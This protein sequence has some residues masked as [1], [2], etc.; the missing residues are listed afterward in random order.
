MSL[1]RATC[2]EGIQKKLVS[3]SFNW[4]S[5]CN[6]EIQRDVTIANV[7]QLCQKKF[8]LQPQWM[9]HWHSCHCRR[10][11]FYTAVCHTLLHSYQQQASYRLLNKHLSKWQYYTII[12][13]T[14]LRQVFSLAPLILRDHCCVCGLCLVEIVPDPC[15]KNTWSSVWNNM[16]WTEVGQ[17]GKK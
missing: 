11:V 12:T 16:I 6:Q 9:E 7:I 10:Y 13:P 14:P 1:I 15:I 4:T 2:W 17:R 3:H 5:W 8:S